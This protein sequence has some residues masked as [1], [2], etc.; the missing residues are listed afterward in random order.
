MT[1]LQATQNPTNQPKKTHANQ[2]IRLQRTNFTVYLRMGLIDT[3]TGLPV[4]LGE[5]ET[6]CSGPVTSMQSATP[7]NQPTTTPTST[8]YYLE[9]TYLLRLASWEESAKSQNIECVCLQGLLVLLSSRKMNWDLV[10]E[11]HLQ[12]PLKVRRRNRNENSIKQANKKS[13]LLFLS[14]G[15]PSHLAQGQTPIA[16]KYILKNTKIWELSPHI[17][18]KHNSNNTPW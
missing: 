18:V 1:C 9:A 14:M 17:D 3:V 4:H 15:W 2:L 10:V 7:P 11:S 5:L 6:H 16:P 12:L 13:V 8:T